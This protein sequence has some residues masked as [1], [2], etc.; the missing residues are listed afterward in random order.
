MKRVLSISILIVSLMCGQVFAATNLSLFDLSGSV[1]E[2]GVQESPYHRNMTELKKEINKLGKADSILVLGFGK[3]SDV[4]LLKATMPN[5]GGPMNRNL[6]G[7][8]EAAIK[9]LQENITNKARN[10]DNS[11]TDVIG[12]IFR[13]VRLFN[14]FQDQKSS[15]P[16]VNRLLIYSDMLDNENLTLSLNTL[17]SGD[18]KKFLRSFESKNMGYPDLRNVEV[19]IYCA[20]SDIKDL[21]TAETEIA[22]R[23]LKAFWSEFFSKSSADLKSFR[24]IY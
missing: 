19:N 7:T 5:M 9:K 21:S 18:H 13:A 6:I 10:I 15:G 12:G 3:K 11:K 23:T 1:I 16:Q 8:K 22:I 17:K 4:V 20:F 24:T 2:G 14:D